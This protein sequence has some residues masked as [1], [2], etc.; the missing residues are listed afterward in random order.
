VYSREDIDNPRTAHNRAM[1]GS[2]NPKLSAQQSLFFSAFSETVG[3]IGIKQEK[4]STCQSAARSS[5]PDDKPKTIQRTYRFNTKLF[6]A[7]RMTALLTCP[8]RSG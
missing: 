8:T 7:L 6:E 2:G 3:I 5:K 1:G 4:D